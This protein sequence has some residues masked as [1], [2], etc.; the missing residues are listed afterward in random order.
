MKK[1]SYNLDCFNGA[2]AER[3]ERPATILQRI[4]VFV[5]KQKTTA[6]AVVKPGADDGT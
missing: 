6:R 1:Q 4:Y 3:S 5:V 2:V